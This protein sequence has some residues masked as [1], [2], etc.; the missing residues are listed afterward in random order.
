M[1]GTISSSK[2][3]VIAKSAL[4]RLRSGTALYKDELENMLRALGVEYEVP[5]EDIAKRILISLIINVYGYDGRSLILLTSLGL[6]ADYSFLNITQ[7][8]IK[9]AE[10]CDPGTTTEAI[11]KKEDRLLQLF[12]ETLQ[13]RIATEGNKLIDEARQSSLTPGIICVTDYGVRQVTLPVI[14]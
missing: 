8:R 11:R 10:H 4:I 6:I 7:R 14:G 12:V 5:T 2:E 13:K 9:I 3:Y 1:S